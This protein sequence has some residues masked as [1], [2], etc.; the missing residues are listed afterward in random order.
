MTTLVTGKLEATGI[1]NFSAFDVTALFDERIDT[2]DSA[3]EFVPGRV[4]A[5][6]E[7]TG[8]FRLEI[9]DEKERSGPV[10][11]LVHRP[12][13]LPAAQVAIAESGPF[14]EIIIKVARCEPTVVTPGPDLTLGAQIKYTGRA[15]DPT[16]RGLA[17][18]LLVV[19]WARGDGAQA[20]SPVSVAKIAT[21]G[22][23]SDAWPSQRFERAFAVISG[24]EPVPVPLE[25]NH[26]P[27][28]LVLVSP[29]V[30][31]PPATRD[32]CDCRE[33]PPR[34][35]DAI[36]LASN[37]QA[38]A[39][40]SQ[41]CI[42]FTIP[43][44]TVEEV[45]YQA[46]VRT[47]QPELKGVNPAKAPTIPETFVRQL[48]ELAQLRPVEG[49]RPLTKRP[50][51]EVLSAT[52][53]L[54]AVTPFRSRTVA[55]AADRLSAA[56]FANALALAPSISLEGEVVSVA[57]SPDELAEQI[58]EARL[59]ANRPLKLEPSVLADLAREPGGITPQ[60]LIEAEHTSVVRRFRMLTDL[61]DSPR[62]ARFQLDEQHQVDW[63]A[64][65]D[66][67]QATTIA[68]GHL[69]T[70]KQVWRADGYSLGDLLYSLPLAPGQQKLISTLDWSRTEVSTRRAQRRETEELAA[71]LSHDRD[72]T[73]IIRSTLSE[74]LDAESHANISS[75]GGA[76]GGFLGP[77]VFG[78]AGG[79]SS[80]SS[81][82]SQ[83]SARSVTGSAL[84]R[85]RDRTVQ[86]ASAV[87]S[88][89][90]TV[91]Q[92]AR[93]GESVRA[94]TEVVA[95]NNH[96]HAIT[97][98]YF[99]VLR[100]FQVTQELAQVQECLFI[101]FAITPF[102]EQ[103]ALRWREILGDRLRKPDLVDAFDAL[104]RK[105]NNWKNADMPDG[106]YA[107]DR[108]TYLEGDFVIRVRLPRPADDKDGNFVQANWDA[109]TDLLAPLGPDPKAVW[110]R[111]LQFAPREHR[112]A[113]WDSRI[114]PGVAQRIVDKL[115]LDLIDA[116]STA[117][118]VPVDP[119][120]VGRFA[121]GRPMRMGL[122]AIPPLPNVT[123][124]QV[125][126]VRLSLD[127]PNPPPGE[128]LIEQA[129]IHYRTQYFA[130]PLF[131]A[132]RILN[133]L[134]VGDVVEIATPLDT[135]EKR[136]PRKRDRRYAERL[137][138]HLNDHIEYYHRALWTDMNPNRRYMLLDG[139]LAPDAGGRSVAS[140]VE[141]R[142]IGIVGNCLVMPVTPGHKLDCT[143]EFA[144]ATAEDLRNLYAAD[145][146]PP[147]RI[148]V[149]TSGVFADVAMGKCNSCEKID[150]SVFWR[151]EEAPI[152]DQP[153]AIA[154]LSTD[155]RR[156][157]P[158]SLAPDQ[159]PEALVRLQETPAAPAP[160]GLAAAVNALGVGNI[161]K[162]LTG[163]A[164]NQENAAEA[165]K[166]SLKTAQGF[167]T[168]A[169]ALAQQKFLNRQLDRGLENIKEALKQGLIDKKQAQARTESLF[170]GAIG[171]Q[172]PEKTSP[173][174][175]PTMQKAMERVGTAKSGSYRRTSPEGTL[176]VKTGGAAGGRDIDV[177]IDPPIDPLKQPTN[178]T[179]WAAGGAMMAAW[180]AQQSM[181]IE[182]ALDK[183][184]GEWRGK[185]QNNEALTTA[186]ARA[187]FAALG[188]V[189]E[190]P[191]SY[192]PEG[193]ARLLASKGPLLEISDDDIENNRLVHLR[194]ITAVRGDGS[195]ERTTVSYAD[196][197]TS[198]IDN[199]SFVKFDRRH[200]ARDV[201]RFGLGL[202]HF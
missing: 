83:T 106:R 44:R 197:D 142:I 81:S 133:D 195:F 202:F 178:K 33:D 146:A 25:N 164:L 169:G 43:N 67:Y 74:R 189:E 187:F 17:A 183:L 101:P 122:R 73:D 188:L 194:I 109:Y 140:V 96:C 69:L 123:R 7:P 80:A 91:V 24:G 97:V 20:E 71:D 136:N 1:D 32:D 58:L 92:T 77:F 63:D 139:F 49:G 41:R 104:E 72:I 13:G 113:I 55:D 4:V 115:Q 137:I 37:P 144:R 35:P 40:D 100:H 175:E 158:P 28:R 86:S 98:E 88:Q 193:L 180:R 163:L 121:Q 150:E 11:L 48:A 112:D 161:F 167:A 111:Y 153:T 2:G 18:N 12:D 14:R 152:P 143:Y 159:F 34:A 60:R 192:T 116:A 68:H 135:E 31:A 45:T 93:Q 171:E 117:R 8:S 16:G 27:L 87:R 177:T 70:L 82:A 165:L 191:A 184:G 103:K 23:F 95:N 57:G 149:P 5:R 61:L 147:M 64:N 200:T 125:R 166:T 199:E 52:P 182:T 51:V 172:R 54:T 154:P 9:P 21:G 6:P 155:T 162:D 107:D 156:T 30:P 130:H 114:S 134:T 120:L 176:E 66:A 76:L 62:A 3:F 160:T 119:T 179:C 186:E 22:Y 26:L 185:F 170:R 141:N 173:T 132:H 79:V 127:L 201:V 19:I 196:T 47:T 85:V 151:W 75:G 145:P 128:I 157:A 78:A 129:A 168:K 84:N 42:E 59:R 29:V 131:A 15:I 138:D 36:D 53:A 105:L 89:R 38:F 108:I 56:V 190:G 102:N 126:S 46:V 50:A 99:E 10:T 110:D 198:A 90:S 181:T 124:A 39:A 148:S 65:S 174:E 118:R 94:Q